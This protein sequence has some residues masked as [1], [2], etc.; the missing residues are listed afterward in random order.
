MEASIM[1]DLFK[2]TEATEG[3]E[4]AQLSKAEERVFAYLDECYEQGKPVPTIRQIREAVKCSNNVISPV[5]KTWTKLREDKDSQR[6]PSERLMSDATREAF[7]KFATLLVEDAKRIQAQCAK[8]I[9]AVRAESERKQNELSALFATTSAN[10]NAQLIRVGELSN[11]LKHLSDE[12]ERLKRERQEAR[13]AEEVAQDK[14]ERAQ[15]RFKDEMSEAHREIKRLQAI[16][17]NK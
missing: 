10:L 1:T 15:Q 8:D 13:R 9:E 6:D 5:L 4:A 2:T 3:V 16:V 14:L 11:E 12:C 17:N 7:N